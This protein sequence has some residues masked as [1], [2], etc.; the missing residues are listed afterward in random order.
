MYNYIDRSIFSITQDYIKKAIEFNESNK[1]E[2]EEI[3][4][5]FLKNLDE[6]EKNI[7]LEIINNNDY[8]EKENGKDIQIIDDYNSENTIKEYI[9]I[10]MINSNKNE[11]PDL[12]NIILFIPTNNKDI[13]DKINEYIKNNNKELIKYIIYGS[14][15]NYKFVNNIIE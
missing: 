14:L 1:K 9:T 15:D 10:S 5:I 7:F 11:E 6:H 4:N 13:K 8:I 3:K 12:Y 2:I